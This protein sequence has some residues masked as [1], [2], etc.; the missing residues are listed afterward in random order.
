WLANQANQLQKMND[1]HDT[2]VGPFAMLF[3]SALG[4]VGAWACY[5]MAVGYQSGGRVTPPSSQPLL[6]FG[7]AGLCLAVV[8]LMNAGW[9]VGLVPFV[10]SKAGP[11]AVASTPTDADVD[12][13]VGITG[14]VEDVRG[15]G[16][17]YRDRPARLTGSNLDVHPW[18]LVRRSRGN[19]PVRPELGLYK[20]TH[21]E[22][23]TAV[24]VLVRR[25]A[26][27]FIWRHG[28]V[29]LTF[30]S[31]AERDLVYGYLGA[32]WSRSGT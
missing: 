17:R 19:A 1:S 25:P 22:L 32:L 10:A 4:I 15:H 24:L 2:A 31:V 12:I 16:R 27:R 14:V 23:G 5:E 28:P 8:A 29:I 9:Y 7:L 6:Q 21:L 30:R 18:F 20:G 3:Q 11:E 26:V 13:D